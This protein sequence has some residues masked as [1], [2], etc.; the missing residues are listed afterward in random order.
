[1]NF[2]VFPLNGAVLFPN[3][4]LPLNIFE[5]RY[6]DMVD[7]ALSKDIFRTR[8]YPTQPSFKNKLTNSSTVPDIVKAW[9]EN[10]INIL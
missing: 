5:E 7:Y 1:M 9:L 10:Q 8:S 6:I 3:T 4:N 2:P